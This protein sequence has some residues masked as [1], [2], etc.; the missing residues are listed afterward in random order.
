MKEVFRVM[1]SAEYRS[2]KEAAFVVC[3]CCSSKEPSHL[4]FMIDS[5]MLGSFIDLLTC[6][7]AN[8]VFMVRLII[9]RLRPFPVPDSRSTRLSAPLRPELPSLARFDEPSRRKA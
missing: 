5:G 6:M 1:E 8:L 2:R 7:D 9:K 3:H 4:N